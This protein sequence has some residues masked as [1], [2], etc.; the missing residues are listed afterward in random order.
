MLD[1]LLAVII[2]L[3][4]GVALA[5]PLLEKKANA[6]RLIALAILS[7]EV[8]MLLALCC[9]TN[10]GEITGSFYALTRHHVLL[11]MCATLAVAIAT[12]GSDMV[13]SWP[14]GASFQCLVLI[15]A[16]GLYAM[17]IARDLLGIVS[18][19]IL[20]SIASYAMTALAKDERSSEGAAKY[21]IM[22]SAS[23]TLLFLGVILT[24]AALRGLELGG[25]MSLPEQAALFMALLF[26]AAMG[27]KMGVFPFHGWLPDTYGITYPALIAVVSCVAKALA[28]MALL[29]ISFIVA[30]ALGESWL[31]IL[32]FFSIATMLY[33]NLGALLQN[34]AQRLLAFSSIAHAGYLLT[35]LASLSPI[36]GA[37]PEW[38]IAGLIIHYAA[39]SLAKAGSFLTLAILR[40]ERESTSLASLRGL[41]RE[42]PVLAGS[43]AILL[44]SLMGMPPLL[45]FWGKLYL[46]ASVVF[47]APWL[48]A[49]ALLNTAVSVAYYA[50]VLKAMY[51][52]A[53]E[54][55]SRFRTVKVEASR[56]AVLL[57]A[58]LTIALGLGPIQI[59][60]FS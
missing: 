44:L 14:T 50:R 43:F 53:S 45:G 36:Q 16:A 52:E 41:G 35:G 30:P 58:L 47:S 17:S 55:A 27:F 57:T 42:D 3:P 29:K 54:A 26:I 51:F 7:A 40:E 13:L 37:I 25:S 2:C 5:L 56:K 38:G 9:I 39:Y 31:Y 46:F 21:A 15:M 32:A 49:A 22:G 11:A 1:Y 33:G 18:A 34:D 23:T 24:Y 20:T 4:G 28:L 6:A 8:P 59:V 10:A 48:T 19:W 60:V 12:Y